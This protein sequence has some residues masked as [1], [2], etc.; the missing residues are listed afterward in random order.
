MA[1]KRSRIIYASQSV[2]IDGMQTNRVQTLG[3]TTTFRNEDIYELGQLE[4]IDVVDDIP[5]VAV[6]LDHNN[7]D[8]SVLVQKLCGVSIPKGRLVINAS[9][10]DGVAL[11]DFARTAHK[12]V[13]IWAPVQ[14]ES[15][16]GARADNTIE[17]TMFMD[18]CF[19]NRLDMA[20][21]VGA[22]ATENYTLETD[23]KTW[24]LNHGRYVNWVAVSGGDPGWTEVDS[25]GF[26]ITIASGVNICGC[27][28]Q[29]RLSKDKV[30]FLFK[31]K[32]LQPCVRIKVNG[33]LND[34]GT[35]SEIP[36]VS[37]LHDSPASTT[38]AMFYPAA[39]EANNGLI[40]LRLP[41]G[42]VD[43]Y[44]C[45]NIGASD[46]IYM[47]YCADG[48]DTTICPGNVYFDEDAAKG[49]KGALRQGQIEAYIVDKNGY[50][51]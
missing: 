29:N 30:G 9:G 40:K 36:I 25:K 27:S 33:Y 4:L 32:E 48:Y 49:Q 51:S 10:Y 23:N 31:N 21:T 3:S 37:G 1:T 22:N 39:G 26:E 11:S 28:G 18:N 35:I 44:N 12:G 6:T 13:A 17:S 8:S 19:V 50:L 16:M 43:G 2:F 42:T 34:A 38:S 46:K 45:L 41:S 24:L 47:A 14:D 5:A 15:K 20:F 7:V